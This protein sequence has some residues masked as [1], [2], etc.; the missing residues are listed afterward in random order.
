MKE[1][2]SCS[3]SIRSFITTIF[4]MAA[5]FGLVWL[6][7]DYRMVCIIILV[8]FELLILVSF[9]FFTSYL[10]IT[11]Q[12]LLIYHFLRW[13]TIN[14]EDI[15]KVEVPHDLSE[16]HSV[17]SSCGFMGYWG[18]YRDSEGRKLRASFN[19]PSQAF[20]IYLRG[21]ERII[22]SCKNRQ[23]IVGI[24]NSIIQYNDWP[25]KEF[26]YTLPLSQ[27][28]L[29]SPDQTMRDRLKSVDYL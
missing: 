2:F 28:I 8:V 6:C 12:G 14:Y 21:G 29:T 4:V 26:L 18:I 17:I 10:N 7:N 24:I 9:W 27:P 22:L 11:P 1:S 20:V 19:N 5:L 23:K 16:Y 15:E 3:F 25:G 13:R